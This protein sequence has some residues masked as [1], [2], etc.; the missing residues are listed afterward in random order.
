M[1]PVI[2]Q[3]DIYIISPPDLFTL[4]IKTYFD[5][6]G[7]YANNDYASIHYGTAAWSFWVLFASGNLK[8]FK[9]G[10]GLENVGDI[11]L[12]DGSAAWQ[13]WRFEVDKT[14]G[15][16]D[17]TVEVFL[18]GVSQGTFDC[19]LEPTSGAGHLAYY[20]N[21]Y[22]TDNLV[23]HIDYIRIATGHGEIND[24]AKPQVMMF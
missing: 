3:R 12:H 18:G 8:I 4:E 23:S 6:L 21:G 9:T 14:D 17:A 15:E 19:D 1:Q 16:A 7:A 24:V 22:T 13:V 20:H 10:W 5:K 2:P 11:V